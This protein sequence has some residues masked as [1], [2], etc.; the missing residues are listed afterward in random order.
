[1][2]DDSKTPPQKRAV[3]DARPLVASMTAF[4]GTFVF[5]GGMVVLAEG[6]FYEP[7]AATLDWGP[8]RS[9]ITLVLG[10]GI[11]ASMGCANKGWKAV[12]MAFLAGSIFALVMVANIVAATVVLWALD[13]ALATGSSGYFIGNLAGLFLSLPVAG[14]VLYLLRPPRA[15]EPSWRERFRSD[16]PRGPMILRVVLSA[17]VLYLAWLAAS[18]IMFRLAPAYPAIQGTHFFLQSSLVS[19]VAMFV[20]TASLPDLRSALRTLLGALV[21]FEAIL[22]LAISGTAVLATLQS[23]KILLAVTIELLLLA[24]VYLGAHV[25]AAHKPV[26]RG[27][28]VAVEQGEEAE[29]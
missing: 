19:A 22:A 12:P 6:W 5:A 24:P 16:G 20:A 28:A 18:E 15:W 23:D 14:G 25:L 29:A 21:L 26:G 10:A 8:G 27:D 1:M 2:S 11:L 13:P 3:L 17:A 9:Y 4:A 7:H